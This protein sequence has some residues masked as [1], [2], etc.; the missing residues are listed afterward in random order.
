M[1]PSQGTY[2]ITLELISD[3]VA[4]GSVIA[5]ITKEIK[6][7]DYVIVI[8]GDSNASGE[9][10]PDIKGVG[11]DPHHERSDRDEC[12]TPQYSKADLP[13]IGPD[14]IDCDPDP[15]W[16][17]PKGHR[18]RLSGHFRAATN[19]MDTNPKSF[20]TILSF[21]NSGASIMKGMLGRQYDDW[22]EMGQIDEARQTLGKRP[23]DYILMSMGINQIE[24]ADWLKDMVVEELIGSPVE[25]PLT[26]GVPPAL[27][28][29]ITR[30]LGAIPYLLGTQVGEKIKESFNGQYKV[31][32]T[33]Y[34]EGLFANS[35]GDIVEGCELFGDGS[36][37]DYLQLTQP[38]AMK[39]EEASKLLNQKV[40][41][42]I[43]RYNSTIDDGPQWVLIT[44]IAAKFRE[45]HGYCTVEGTRFFVRAKE[46]CYN[47]CDWEG[48]IHPNGKG[49]A[50][51]AQL[52]AAYIQNDINSLLPI[53]IH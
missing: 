33:E 15:V 11:G 37:Y 18:S 3:Y 39:V 38:E 8:F 27:P 6:V 52:I 2:R 16:I 51:T 35:T 49:H 9:G 31:L 53:T 48:T 5:T 17:E 26:P 1:L 50:V 7:N 22:Q 4:W 28:G 14:A 12:N 43:S 24:F 40:R 20:F 45:G 32:L 10:N 44:G 19:L 42:S 21:A 41:E 47:Q 29:D 13:I 23:V 36:D 34:P 30:K 46:S 25:A